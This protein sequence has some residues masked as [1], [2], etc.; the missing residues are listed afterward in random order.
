MKSPKSR[1]LV[2]AVLGICFFSA[3]AIASTN[4]VVVTWDFNPGN[5]S[6]NVGSATNTYT[7]S[8]YNLTVR[9]YD[10]VA[11]ADT[12]HDL[13]YKNEPMSGG[14]FERGLGL[15]G[16]PANEF[17]LNGNGAPANYLQLD[18][19]SILSQGFT[20]GMLQ[21][22]SLQVGESFQLFGSN[23]MGEMGTQLGGTWAGLTFDNQ[24]ISVPDFGSYQFIS[25]AAASGQILPVAFR[26]SITPIPEMS[27]LFPMVGLLV[28]VYST[29]VLRRRRAAQ[30][31]DPRD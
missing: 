13:Y 23:A 14:A 29:Q 9:G 4:A 21:V 3:F 19:R 6:A 8:G 26:A 17:T 25:V 27:V 28:A 15:V 11:G 1:P 22:A 2:K 16:T 31:G 5:L 30:L 12:L 24:F 10:S 20:N 18:L 7:Q